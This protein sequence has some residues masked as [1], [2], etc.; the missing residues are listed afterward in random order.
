MVSMVSVVAMA[1]G[2][3]AGVPAAVNLHD[4]TVEQCCA[5]GIPLG[6]CQLAITIRD[7]ARIT[8]RWVDWNR[9]MRFIKAR[10]EFAP[11]NRM[12]NAGCVAKLAKAVVKK[13][14]VSLINPFNRRTYDVVKMPGYTAS[15]VFPRA[16]DCSMAR[17]SDRC[18]KTPSTVMTV[19]AMRLGGVQNKCD[20]E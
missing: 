7:D 13:K 11:G 2:Y 10:S 8:A 14:R 3:G 18:W 5:T 12:C 1:F 20:G 16:G 17:P 6:A 19:E 15:I 4:A 9:F